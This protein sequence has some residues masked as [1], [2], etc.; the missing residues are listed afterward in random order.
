MFL[1]IIYNYV[2]AHLDLNEKPLKQ[3]RNHLPFLKYI[4]RTHGTHNNNNDLRVFLDHLSLQDSNKRIHQPAT[5][6]NIFIINPTVIRLIGG[7]K[8]YK[9]F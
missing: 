3:K 2:I 9:H 4:R 7:K 6:G 1:P 8:N 5:I